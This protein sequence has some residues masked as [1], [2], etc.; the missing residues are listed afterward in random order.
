M[1]TSTPSIVE[2]ISL[3]KG[4]E[5]TASRGLDLLGVHYIRPL[6]REDGT[7]DRKSAPFMKVRKDVEVAL[8]DDFSRHTREVGGLILEPSETTTAK[9]RDAF[10]LSKG[11]MKKLSKTDADWVIATAVKNAVRRDWNRIVRTVL[12]KS[13]TEGDAGDAGDAD[14]APGAGTAAGDKAAKVDALTDAAILAAIHN[15]VAGAPDASSA[16]TSLQS[17]ETLAKRLRGDLKAGRKVEPCEV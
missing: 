13:D 16:G 15:F 14:A 6:V 9:V 10:A 17:V 4:G 7:V 11:V 3:F 2:C 5:R 8:V 12:P 1:S